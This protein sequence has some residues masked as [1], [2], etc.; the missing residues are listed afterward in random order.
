MLA[1]F[2]VVGLITGLV[3]A[4]PV[5]SVWAHCMRRSLLSGRRAGV[6]AGL[7]AA[8]ADVL[9][10]IVAVFGVSALSN[11]FETYR[12]HL[13]IFGSILLFWIGFHSL[14][15]ELP[16]DAFTRKRLFSLYDAVGDFVS[17]FVL[18]MTNPTT[19]LSIAIA[20]TYFG[21]TEIAKNSFENGVA[22][23]T[24]VFVGSLIWWVVL[25]L[26]VHYLKSKMD[27][28][29]WRVVNKVTGVIMII[30]GILLLL[31]IFWLHII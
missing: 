22:L 4:I 16:T 30:I 12:D 1:P 2:F 23:V 7:G 21:L 11:F 17:T 18:S 9:F 31:D 8:T 27:E 6:V 29:T 10:A 20:V 5:G 26:L 24:G 13:I 3:I 15:K 14:I 19:I 28:K 25:S